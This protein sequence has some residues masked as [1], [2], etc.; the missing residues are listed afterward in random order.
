MARVAFI[1]FYD[2][3]AVGIRTMG[4]Y[5]KS[6]GHSCLLVFV[7]KMSFRLLEETIE[8]N[9]NYMAL[10]T[11]ALFGHCHDVSPISTSEVAE[12]CQKLQEF[13]PDVVGFSTR[14]FYDE[15]A[16]NIIG[17]IR[18]HI[19][20]AFFVAGGFGPTLAYEKWLNYVDI[21]V[22]GD[23]EE[24]IADIA[25]CVDE[26]R[27]P[28]GIANTVYKKN[29]KIVLQELRPPE[30]RLSK[31]PHPFFPYEHSI[32]IEHDGDAFIHSSSTEYD[33]L[34]GRGC[35]GT[36]AYCS[37][38]NWR[39]LYKDY[40]ITMP[41][42]RM[43]RVEDIIS[44]L[45]I[46]KEKG[47][48]SVRILD[49]F[50]VAPMDV[51][52]R[53]FERYGKEIGLPFAT[54]LH[55]KITSAHPGF[56][57][58]LVEVGLRSSVV[59]IQTGDENFSMD[60]YKRKQNN[61][62][63]IAFADSLKKVG[64]SVAYHFI[65]GN[66]IQPDSSLQD[67]FDLI[68]RLPFEPG[69]DNINI[70]LFAPFPRSPIVERFGMQKLSGYDRK[71]WHLESL[72]MTMRAFCNDEEFE[73]V[74][75]ITTPSELYAKMID[76]CADKMI[77]GEPVGLNFRLHDAVVAK[78]LEKLKGRSIYL[79]GMSGGYE[80]IRE[81]LGDVLI[82]AAFDNDPGKQGTTSSEGVP[83]LSPEALPT[84]ERLPVVI[85]STYYNEIKNQIHA[86]D[87]SIATMYL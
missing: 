58:F 66:P 45:L 24:A 36:C 74:M 10:C 72:Q 6:L 12:V 85:T 64:I 48:T 65:G 23:G 2:E 73:D 82:E 75:K 52:R 67:N 41:P 43:R 77:A 56:L 54:F 71:R 25:A 76:F 22:R 69:K 21:V 13:Q 11:G 50:M 42:R 19:P 17:E 44:E 61:A 79:W 39:T 59:A 63:I 60:V 18:R 51:L 84:M 7:K 20:S 30:R 70:F 4:S 14:S 31:Y 38:G 1:T 53:L 83:I 55:P 46:A 9:T 8:N 33:I 87:P 16:K 80:R 78:V 47:Y 3:H 40:D 62:N 37:G 81:Q 68:R 86:M 15:I 5:L 49:E 32:Y 34:M 28:E 57:E 26:K 27:S 29:G 35:V